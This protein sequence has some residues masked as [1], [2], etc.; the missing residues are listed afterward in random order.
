MAPNWKEREKTLTWLGKCQ[1]WVDLDLASFYDHVFSSL[2]IHSSITLQINL[3]NLCRSETRSIKT[4]SHIIYNILRIWWNVIFV[5]PFNC[6]ACYYHP[7]LL[8]FKA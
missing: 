7:A 2:I 8:T 1:V 4:L 5:V 6:I 3:P